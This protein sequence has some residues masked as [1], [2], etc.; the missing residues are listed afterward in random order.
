MFPRSPDLIELAAQLDSAVSDIQ[1]TDSEVEHNETTITRRRRRGGSPEAWSTNSDSPTPTNSVAERPWA[2]E[3]LWQGLLGD[4]HRQLLGTEEESSDRHS[5]DEEGEEDALFQ[6]TAE[7]KDY[8]YK[9]FIALQPN[10]KGLL[11]GHLAR[12]FF[13][14][15]KIPTE[16][17][18]IIWHLSDVTRDG[19]LS[20]EEF[21]AAMHLIVLRRHNIPIPSVLPLC[22]HP[23][24][25]LGEVREADLLHLNDDVDLDKTLVDTPKGSIDGAV[26]EYKR[27]RPEKNIMNLSG[28]SQVSFCFRLK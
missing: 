18:R 17:L 24:V 14:K 23:C 25:I 1:S 10:P 11:S 19:S 6:M 16:E 3:S 5:S 2:K 13:E 4:E 21:T 7:Q 8:Y 15:S 28:S 20:L 26:G 27:P 22:L 12:V 9:Q